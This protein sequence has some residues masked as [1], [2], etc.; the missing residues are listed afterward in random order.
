M[1]IPNTKA[2]KPCKRIKY[3]LAVLRDLSNCWEANITIMWGIFPIPEE[4]LQ[5]LYSKGCYL[6]SGEFNLR[7]ILNLASIP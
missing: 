3:I 4:T 5:L 6:Y 7:V 2:C 1:V